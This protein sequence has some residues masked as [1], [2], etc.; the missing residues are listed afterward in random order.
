MKRVLCS[1]FIVLLVIGVCTSCAN[2]TETFNKKESSIGITDL[3]EPNSDK[4]TDRSAFTDDLQEE[5][6][7]SDKPVVDDG[8]RICKENPNYFM[9]PVVATMKRLGAVVEWENESIARISISGNTYILDIQEVILTEEGY[10]FNCISP[11]PGAELYFES[12]EKELFLDD[13][14]FYTVFWSLGL[15]Y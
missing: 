13:V 9:L 7:V 15:E 5:I 4:E 2:K 11:P 8:R 12:G 14:T 1:A 10:D 6:D 3:I